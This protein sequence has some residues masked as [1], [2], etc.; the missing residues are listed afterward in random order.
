MTN[1]SYKAL[2]NKFIY[3]KESWIRL[4]SNECGAKVY[5]DVETKTVRNAE[6]SKEDSDHAETCSQLAYT[7]Q[8]A[9]SLNWIP[10]FS[11]L[12]DT[13]KLIALVKSTY[14]EET[15][16]YKDADALEERLDARMTFNE[17]CRS[18]WNREKY[19]KW[20]YKEQT[21]EWKKEE[22]IMKYQWQEFLRKKQIPA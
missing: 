13:M 7:K 15:Q 22:A 12:T 5:F 18:E 6:K 19:E 14:K 9:A 1:Y 10:S 3:P 20:K 17:E 4:C 16:I 11:F 8:R 2:Y 21:D